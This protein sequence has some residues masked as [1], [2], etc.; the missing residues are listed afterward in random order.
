AM[1]IPPPTPRLGVRLPPPKP[2]RSKVAVPGDDLA[3][4][5][6]KPPDRH[7]RPDDG[8]IVKLMRKYGAPIDRETYIHFAYGA[9]VPEM[10]PELESHLPPELQDWSQFEGRQ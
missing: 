9:A 5:R 8:G 2:A 6:A 10:A 7:P 4:A 1:T 3:S